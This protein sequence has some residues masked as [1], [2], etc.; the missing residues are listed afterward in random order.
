MVS[1]YHPKNPYFDTNRIQKQA[2]D[3]ISTCYDDRKLL[4]THFQ[5]LMEKF[6]KDPEVVSVLQEATKTLPH[7]AKATDKVVKV[8]DIMTKLVGA[9]EDESLSDNDMKMLKSFAEMKK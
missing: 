4:L 8:L 9:S 3:L 6:E 5:Y 2:K 7:L 1:N